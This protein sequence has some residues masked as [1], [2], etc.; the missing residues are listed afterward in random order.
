[1]PEKFLI[2]RKLAKGR[3]CCFEWIHYLKREK[4]KNVLGKYESSFVNQ[5]INLRIF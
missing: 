4:T 2:H 1:M 3:K 5:E